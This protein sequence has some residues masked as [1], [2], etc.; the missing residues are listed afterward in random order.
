MQQ[1]HDTVVFRLIK[2][3]Q[4]TNK[5]KNGALQVL[6]FLTKNDAEK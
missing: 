5:Q 4:L 2:G 1:M 6:I 3:G